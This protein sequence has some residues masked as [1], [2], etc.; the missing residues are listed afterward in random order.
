MSL[1][2]FQAYASLWL[3]G[4]AI[5]VL[6]AVRIAVAPWLP[7]GEPP[8]YAL[9]MLGAADAR[10]PPACRITVRDLS[11][12]EI[13]VTTAARCDGAPAAPT[14]ATPVR[15]PGQAALLRAM[16]SGLHSGLVLALGALASWGLRKALRRTFRRPAGFAWVQRGA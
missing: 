9:W 8:E 10:P 1:Q 12:R 6:F 5:V 13:L 7:S 3:L 2:A 14:V 11:G 4:T 16:A 15:T